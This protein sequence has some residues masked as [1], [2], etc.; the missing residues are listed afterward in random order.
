MSSQTGTVTANDFST[1]LPI[2]RENRRLVDSLHEKVARRAYELYERGGRVDGDDL[3]YWLQAE[4]E[5]LAKVPEVRE[6]LALYTVNV[7]IQGFKPE[8]VYVGVDANRAILLAEKR[9]S[10]DGREA[11]ESGFIRESLFLA[12]NWPTAVDPATA[13]AQIR[14]GNLTLTAKRAMP[15]ATS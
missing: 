14:N 5:L 6:S 2:N 11:Q 10:I 13:S 9:E 1:T 8:E 3:R 4:S 15:A 7:P 12:A